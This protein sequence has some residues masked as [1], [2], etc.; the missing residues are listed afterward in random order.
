MIVGLDVTITGPSG[1]LDMY[2]WVLSKIACV[3]TGQTNMIS[4]FH[5]EGARLSG[6]ARQTG[7]ED[8]ELL[9]PINGTRTGYP[10]ARITLICR[11]VKK[12]N[13][14]HRTQLS[15]RCHT[16]PARSEETSSYRL[17]TSLPLYQRHQLLSEFS[18]GTGRK[19][20]KLV[21]G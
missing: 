17:E 9:I 21:D 7:H 11:E 12:G 3:H 8:R 2:T 5:P 1:S 10:W 20:G 4:T 14:N 19:S 13:N 6:V 16:T 15:G 18:Y